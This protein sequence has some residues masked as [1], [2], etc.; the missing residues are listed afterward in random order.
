[1]APILPGVSLSST[2][3]IRYHLKSV[4]KAKFHYLHKVGVT[5]KTRVRDEP[6]RTFFRSKSSSQTFYSISWL[7]AK[8][9]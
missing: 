5:S 8:K 2:V 6:R 3:C 1:M 4:L 7:W 9:K